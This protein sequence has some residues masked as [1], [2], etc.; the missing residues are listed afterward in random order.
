MKPDLPSGTREPVGDTRATQAPLLPFSLWSFRGPVP[1]QECCTHKRKMGAASISSEEGE[2]KVQ[3]DISPGDG[4]DPDRVLMFYAIPRSK[5]R[6]LAGE[7]ARV[8]RPPAS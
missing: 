1:L 2:I 3:K 4:R 5:K 8:E 7:N 6:A